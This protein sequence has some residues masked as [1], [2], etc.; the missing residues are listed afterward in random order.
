M[1]ESVWLLCRAVFEGEERPLAWLRAVK[2]PVQKKGSGENYEHYRGC[3][4]L[5]VV[6]KVF[7]MVIETR[8]REFCESRGLLSQWQFGF[9]EGRACRDS[10]LIV[11]ELLERRD[12]KLFCGFLDVAKAYDSVWRKGMWYKLR[13]LGVR[14]KMLKVVQSLYEV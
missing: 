4:L 3:T 7:G 12:E 5:S 9:R 1:I 13:K 14:G 8:L 11:S 6:G 2:V 10:L